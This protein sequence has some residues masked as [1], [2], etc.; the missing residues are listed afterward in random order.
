MA[1]WRIKRAALAPG[2]V[3]NLPFLLH[4]SSHFVPTSPHLNNGQ[5]G[6]LL[7]LHRTA[8]ALSHLFILAR[9]A[10][11]RTCLRPPR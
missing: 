6:N 11:C 7:D 1:L 10:I 4:I 2:Q 9:S 3:G 8:F 5:V